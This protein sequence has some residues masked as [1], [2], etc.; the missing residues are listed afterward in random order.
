MYMYYY[1]KCILY[2]FIEK[3][4]TLVT[5]SNNR[6]HACGVFVSSG[7][8]FFPKSGHGMDICIPFV[9]SYLRFNILL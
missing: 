7:Y 6:A 1:N 3:L 2:Y 5:F 9:V 4:A 8:E